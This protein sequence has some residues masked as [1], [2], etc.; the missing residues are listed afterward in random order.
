ML[1]RQAEL[2][3]QGKVL[4]ESFHEADYLVLIL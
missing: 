2:I 1:W 3:R 4:T